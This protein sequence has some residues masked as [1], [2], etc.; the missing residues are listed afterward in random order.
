MFSPYVS[1]ANNVVDL[2]E[3]KVY[4]NQELG[5]L[6]LN[7]FFEQMFHKSGLLFS[8]S[9]NWKE[10]VCITNLKSQN[11]SLSLLFIQKYT[12]WLCLIFINNS[13]LKPLHLI[14]IIFVILLMLHPLKGEEWLLRVDN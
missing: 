14:W 3:W 9:Q 10:F 12:F 2:F 1:L 4:E 6:D 13:C 5:E 7:L 11:S 8:L